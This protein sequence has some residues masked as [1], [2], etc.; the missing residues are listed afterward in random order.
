MWLEFIN[1]DYPTFSVIPSTPGLSQEGPGKFLEAI[2]EI[3]VNFKSA[4]I[5][6]KLGRVVNFE[7]LNSKINFISPQNLFRP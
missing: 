6:F 4:P 5:F 7:E 2:P 3:I 1:K